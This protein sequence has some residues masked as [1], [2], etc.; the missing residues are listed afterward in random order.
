MSHDRPLPFIG[1]RLHENRTPTGRRTSAPARRAALYLA[2]GRNK[3]AQLEGRQ[4]GQWLG[5]D[6]R[7]HSQE[8]VCKTRLHG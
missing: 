5:P 7:I 1:V 8:E 2:Y 4:R 3:E 6:G